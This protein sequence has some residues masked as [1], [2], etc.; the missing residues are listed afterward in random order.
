MQSGFWP[1]I[2][3][4]GNKKMKIEKVEKK[5]V[6]ALE[7][8]I[9]I[10]VGLIFSTNLLHFN[11]EIN[12]DIASDAILSTLIWNS[13]KIVPDTWYIANEVRII[14]TP[15]IAALYYGLTGNMILSEGLACCTMTLLLLLSISYFLHCIQ[16]K[17]VN[18]FLMMFAC[19]AIPT[20]FVSLE[21]LYLFASYYAIHM[22]I[23]FFTL[24]VYLKLIR[25]KVIKPIEITACIILAL[26][27]G[28]Q[29][30]R[31][32]L[33][34]Y[35][36]LFG[37]EC[38]RLLYGVYCRQKAD[39]SNWFIG[40]WVIIMLLIS[41]AG[42]CFPISVGQDMSRN[43]RKGLSKLFTIVIP[44]VSRAIG[45]ENTGAIG[46][47]CLSILIAVS[48]GM[49]IY[50]LLHLLKRQD[51]KIEEWG[52]LIICSSPIVTMIIV[53]FTTVES[54]E[55]YY[56]VLLFVMAYAV[57][58]VWQKISNY[59]IWKMIIGVVVVLLALVNIYNIYVPVLTSTEPPESEAYEVTE[60]LIDNGYELAYATFD[61]ANMMTSLANGEIRVAPVASVSKMDICK[62]MSSTDWYVPNVPNRMQTAY[63]V[64]DAKMED[65]T[66][67]LKAHEQDLIL[68]K[69]IGN[70][71]IYIS[72]YNF[73]NL[74]E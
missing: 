4:K 10:F 56:F 29:G 52:Y 40:V 70:Y 11:Y 67:F 58:L 55:R 14:C 6:I 27:L 46:K 2:F 32:I 41:F 43:V 25:S 21:L 18:R 20:G 73:S 45:F 62:W 68:A 54:S 36:P 8:G 49:L 50:I 57:M 30:T 17:K 12:S 39:K 3:R 51:I 74:K 26:I 42:T 34:I 31:G 16:I 9:L 22:V 37:M 69:K 1:I 23:L 28:I 71:N 61:H 19:L 5:I 59:N 44:D 15:N 38:I 72:N 13:K 7:I 33:I 48:V 66:V 64:T 63:I 35:G 53:A 24:G 47:I 65:F 60:Y